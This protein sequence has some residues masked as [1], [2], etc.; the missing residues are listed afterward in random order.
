MKR[1][2]VRAVDDI[3]EAVEK[4][5]C[6]AKGSLTLEH[7]DRRVGVF[8]VRKE[9]LVIGSF[10]VKLNQ[11]S[12]S[13]LKAGLTETLAGAVPNTANHALGGHGIDEE[14]QEE[15]LATTQ[16]LNKD[17]DVGQIDQKWVRTKYLAQLDEP[18]DEAQLEEPPP[19]DLHAVPTTEAAGTPDIPN[20]RLFVYDP[21]LTDPQIRQE[22][23][24]EDVP[25]EIA[26]LDD[27]V[28]ANHIDPA[29]AEPSLTI[30][31]NKGTKVVGLILTLTKDQVNIADHHM[32][33][34]ARLIYPVAGKQVFVYFMRQEMTPAPAPVVESYVPRPDATFTPGYLFEKV[35]AIP[36]SEANP[37]EPDEVKEQMGSEQGFDGGTSE[38]PTASPFGRTTAVSSEPTES[39][40]AAD[41]D[42][43]KGVTPPAGL[44]KATGI[45]WS[46]GTV[47]E[48]TESVNHLCKAIF[49]AGGPASG[50]STAADMIFGL[51]QH[52]DQ[53]PTMAQGVRIVNSDDMLELL[54]KEP[55]LQKSFKDLKDI[56]SKVYKLKPAD[57]GGDMDSREVQNTLRP[58]AKR[59]MSKLAHSFFA[60]RQ[61]V[62]IDGTGKDYEK[63]ENQRRNLKRLG[64]DCHIIVVKVDIDVA[65]KRNRAR[66]RSVPDEVVRKGHTE[67]GA[68]LE[69]YRRSFGNSYHEVESGKTPYEDLRALG[70]SILDAPLKNPDGK[71]WLA[72]MSLVQHQVEEAILEKLGESQGPRGSRKYKSAVAVILHE[73]DVLL[74]LAKADDDRDGKLCF[75]GGGIDPQDGGDPLL[76]ARR[77]AFE[78]TGVNVIPHSILDHPDKDGVAFVVC[79]Y[80]SGQPEP[81]E[82]FTS[83]Q[84]VPIDA[85]K[86]RFPNVYPE[87]RHILWRLSPGLKH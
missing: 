31:M 44:N 10:H 12:T 14:E 75:P 28:L 71:E 79:T 47:R 59:L 9:R 55:D 73:G 76:A 20:T 54:A 27:F 37:E 8:G 68:N 18:K 86:E 46:S 65:I 74:G 56:P 36:V 82:E 33:K 6:L 4:D 83:L 84:W 32:D 39:L 35:K 49:L 52:K 80:S 53:L 11:I 29:T 69:K 77:E 23:F 42:L 81:N 13:K 16:S 2:F 34:Y 43:T 38:P 25:F 60:T 50:K 78:E 87:N 45:H 7:I 51:Q 48:S 30:H 70:D 62:V 5:M 72:L 66:P 64:Y 41:G 22:L 26:Q 57:M 24:G 3:C 61:P 19:E 67:L 63:V 1:D 21:E 17:G 58:V 15:G 85:A 40:A